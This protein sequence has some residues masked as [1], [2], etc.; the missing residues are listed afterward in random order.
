MEF[1]YFTLLKKRTLSS[2]FHALKNYSPLFATLVQIPFA[3]HHQ[4]SFPQLTSTM[5]LDSFCLWSIAF[6]LTLCRVQVGLIYY[7]CSHL[8]DFVKNIPLPRISFVP[9]S[10]PPFHLH[11]TNATYPRPR[12]MQ[13][14]PGCILGL[15]KLSMFHLCLWLNIFRFELFIP[16]FSHSLS[17]NFSPIAVCQQVSGE[18]PIVAQ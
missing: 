5:N 17:Y 7:P 2:I 9:N 18:P 8:F 3:S 4:N 6:F 10:F 11:S 15:P 1:L 13:M 12:L 16:D 14:F